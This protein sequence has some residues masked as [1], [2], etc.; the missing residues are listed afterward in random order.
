MRLSRRQW[1]TKAGLLIPAV[2][3]I[4]PTLAQTLLINSYRFAA[5]GGPDTYYYG[6]GSDT[7]PSVGT[8]FWT[9]QSLG[10]DIT[11]GA[12]GTLTKVGMKVDETASAISAVR[13]TIWTSGTPWV[14]H[15]CVT[16]SVPADADGW[17]DGNLVSPLSVSTS[18]VVR[19]IG[20]EETAASGN[21]GAYKGA[22][23][24]GYAVSG[25]AYVDG[26]SSTE[27]SWGAGDADSIAV[28]VYV[29]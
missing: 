25:R 24:T 12:G 18:Q 15:E 13:V 26:C 9:S 6:I 21:L 1:F 28:R 23:Q 27:P 4:R 17:V 14:L 11:I 20:V 16:L 22:T 29:D 5:G 2:G 7:Y 10:D 3:L 8:Y 19:V